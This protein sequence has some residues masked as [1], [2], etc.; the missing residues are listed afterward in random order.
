MQVIERRTFEGDFS[1]VKNYLLGWCACWLGL[2]TPCFM[3]GIYS[4]F[5]G[6]LPPPHGFVVAI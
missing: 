5:D 4:L 1:N 6:V 2:P 3:V